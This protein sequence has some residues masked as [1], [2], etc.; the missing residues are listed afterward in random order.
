MCQTDNWD[1][2]GFGMFSAPRLKSQKTSER[3]AQGVLGC[4]IFPGLLLKPALLLFEQFCQIV[5][6]API[7]FRDLWFRART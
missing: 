5:Q 2:L 1:F 7:E 3:A 6:S 4:P